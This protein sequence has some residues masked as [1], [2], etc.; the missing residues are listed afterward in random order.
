MKRNRVI[1]GILLAAVLITTPAAPTVANATELVEVQINASDV[2][3][4][5]AIDVSTGPAI[6]IQKNGW[7]TESSHGKKGKRYYRDGKYV[8]GVQPVGKKYYYFG[9]YG[10]RKTREGSAKKGSTRYYFTKDGVIY[11]RRKNG[12]YYYGNGLKMSKADNWDF[13]AQ[14]KADKIVKRLTNSK[15]TKRQK[16]TKCFRWVMD[17]RYVTHRKFN[18][19]NKYWPALNACDI[20]K[21]R[22]GECHGD[23]GAVA[24]LAQAIGYKNVY[25][26]RDTKSH[27]KV[28]H[29]WAEINGRVYDSLFAKARGYNKYYNVS[30]KSYRLHA[31]EHYRVPQFNPKKKGVKITK[32]SLKAEGK[33]NNHNRKKTSHK[34]RKGLV[35]EDR[36]FRYYD[37]NGKIN[38]ARTDLINSAAQRYK[39]VS[40]F[41]AIVGN[42]DKKSYD[43]SCLEDNAQD[44]IWTYRGFSIATL[45]RNNGEEVF[46]NIMR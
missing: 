22:T 1:T 29:S 37:D 45:K 20:F 11:A 17:T 24:Y 35:V 46:M 8:K 41:V 13:T 34:G 2:S 19:R 9:K 44:G 3:T 33:K 18:S 43:T 23:A 42:P 40:E 39:S 31:M 36:Q 25:V 12:R 30:Y 4:G 27:D 16:L 6:V 5:S 7:K 14:Q 38:R 26:C 15:M 28:G 10:F 32:A 21:D